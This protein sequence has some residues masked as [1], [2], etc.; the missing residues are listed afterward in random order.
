MRGEDAKQGMLFP[1]EDFSGP[2][3]LFWVM[4]LNILWSWIYL[5]RGGAVVMEVKTRMAWA[6]GCLK[7]YSKARARRWN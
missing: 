6:W 7:T 1:P 4:P 2:P 5:V 3:E